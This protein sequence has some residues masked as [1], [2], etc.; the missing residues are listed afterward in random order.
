RG[1]VRVGRIIVAGVDRAEGRAVGDAAEPDPVG[2]ALQVR[3][4]VGALRGGGGRVDHVPVRVEQLDRHT[5]NAGL[6]VV[7]D[8][9]TV[10]VGPHP[11]T[12]RA[13]LGR[14][15]ADARVDVGVVV[16]LVTPADDATLLPCAPLFRSRGG[17]RVGRII[18]AGVDR[19][20]G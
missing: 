4:L 19:A 20:E 8:A 11:V 13:Q 16:R 14:C 6:T 17:V 3:E 7:L 2:A 9:V 15:G 12:H 1:G 5:R 18:V 10:R